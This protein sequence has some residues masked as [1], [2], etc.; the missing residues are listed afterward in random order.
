MAYQNLAAAQL[1]AQYSLTTNNIILMR[2]VAGQ[3]AEKL[4]NLFSHGTKLGASMSYYYTTMLGP[5]GGS[6]GYSNLTKKF[7]FYINLGFV[8]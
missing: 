4:K 7:Y 5:L 6:I 2:I 3:D 8:F 1:Q